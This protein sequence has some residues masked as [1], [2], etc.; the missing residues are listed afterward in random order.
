MKSLIQLLK[1]RFHG[2]QATL[3]HTQFLLGSLPPWPLLT[4]PQFNVYT[5]K[6]PLHSHPQQ[7]PNTQL[8]SADTQTESYHDN[9]KVFLWGNILCFHDHCPLE[10]NVRCDASKRFLGVCYADSWWTD[11]IIDAVC[12]HLLPRDGRR[13]GGLSPT[14]MPNQ[15]CTFIDNFSDNQFVG[16]GHWNI[17]RAH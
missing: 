15:T 8:S 1:L 3:F 16:L 13:V 12:L 7:P 14:Q 11:R 4:G 6:T 2:Q 9:L 17:H 10:K 5:Q